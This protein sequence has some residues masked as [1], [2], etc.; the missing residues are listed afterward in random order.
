MLKIVEWTVMVIVP[1]GFDIILIA[2]FVLHLLGRTGSAVQIFADLINAARRLCC[3]RNAGAL[4]AYP[5]G[6]GARLT[7]RS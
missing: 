1:A 3:G 2:G 4:A 7:G 5:A 6:R